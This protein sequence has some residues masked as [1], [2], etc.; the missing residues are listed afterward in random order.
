MRRVSGL[1]EPDGY[2]GLRI[3]AFAG[4]RGDGM[5]DSHDRPPY[6]PQSKIWVRD[7]Q[8]PGLTPRHPVSFLNTSCGVK[9]NAKSKMLH[10]T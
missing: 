6:D 8:P 5:Q 10:F 3:G 2:A 7:P 1:D 9:S 4:C